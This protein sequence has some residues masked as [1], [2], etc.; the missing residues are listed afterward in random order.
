MVANS[1]SRSLLLTDEGTSGTPLASFSLCDSHNNKIMQKSIRHDS[2]LPSP[3]R[4]WLASHSAHLRANVNKDGTFKKGFK[5]LGS[6]DLSGKAP[7]PRRQNITDYVRA[8]N[9][10][11]SLNYLQHIIECP[12]C[13]TWRDRRGYPAGWGRGRQRPHLPERIPR[14]SQGPRRR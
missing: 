4:T 12:K 7:G 8:I 13:L 1:T 3:P 11:P 2:N 14:A 9:F 5:D 10:H 6:G